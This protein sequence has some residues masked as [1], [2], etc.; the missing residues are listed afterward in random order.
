MIKRLTFILALLFAQPAWGAIAMLDAPAN[1]ETENCDPCTAS[2]TISAGSNRKFLC[3]IGSEDVSTPLA[4]AV[5]FNGI[6]MAMAVQATSTTDPNGIAIWYLDEASLPAPGSHTVSVDF[7]DAV[8]DFGITCWS[9]SG[10]ASGVPK[11]TD[12]VSS[13]SLNTATLSLSVVASDWVFTAATINNTSNTWSHG[14]TQTELSDFDYAGAVPSAA[15]SASRAAGEAGPSS[16]FG[17][18]ANRFAMVGAVW[19]E[20]ASTFVPMGNQPKFID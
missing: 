17:G 11:D 19:A 10:I 6:S 3:A 20:A 5:T 14:G 12:S 4:S 13:D 1:S 18:S 15:M 2:F 9:V 7:S 8:V 16:T